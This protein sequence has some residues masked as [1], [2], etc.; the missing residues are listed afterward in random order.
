M[1][2]IVCFCYEI[3]WE[4]TRAF[5]N[6]RIFKFIPYSSSGNGQFRCKNAQFLKNLQAKVTLNTHNTTTLQQQQSTRISLKMKM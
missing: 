5:L 3:G 1:C 4:V 2:K 6:Y